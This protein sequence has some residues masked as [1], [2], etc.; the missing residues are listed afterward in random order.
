MRVWGELRDGKVEKSEVTGAMG[1]DRSA[2]RVLSAG[3]PSTRQIGSS[4]LRFGVCSRHLSALPALGFQFILR[5]LVF[6]QS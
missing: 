1:N 4:M 6:L 5:L 2:L 3:F